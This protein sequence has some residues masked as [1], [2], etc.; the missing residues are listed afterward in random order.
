MIV[1]PVTLTTAYNEEFGENRPVSEET[2]RKLIYNFNLL[3]A[4]LPYAQV[5][6]YQVN[7]PSVKIP[8][9]DYFTF[10]DGGEI[11]APTSPL[12]GAGNQYTPNMANRYLRG[13]SASTTSGNEAGGAA[14]MNWTHTHFIQYV[15]NN[16][17]NL[18]EASDERNAGTPLHNH[19]LANDGSTVPLDLSHMEIAFYLRIDR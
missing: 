18:L 12:N 16:P 2:I 5:V 8:N 10:A 3:R 19:G 7:M 11:T 13:G 14:T 6:A 4:L 9:P 15:G 17:G 1:R